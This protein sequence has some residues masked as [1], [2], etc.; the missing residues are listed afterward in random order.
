MSIIEVKHVTKDYGYG[1]GIFDVSF[2]VKKGEVFGFLGPNGAGKTTTIRH[3]MGFIKA[4]VGELYINGKD[5]WKS[6]A[7]IKREVGYLPGELAF[8]KKLTGDQ[9]IEFMAEER[10]VTDMSWTEKLKEIFELDTSEKI[11]KMSLGTKR[12]LAVVTAFIHDPKV[13][14]LDEPTSGLDPVMQER[15]IQFILNE[16]ERGKTILLSSHI[17]SEVDATCDRIAIIKEGVLVSTI[18]PSQLQR[19]TNKAFKVEFASTKDYQTFIG[20]TEFFIPIERPEQNQVKL[21]ITDEKMQ[22]LFTELSKV[23]VNFISEIKFTLEDYF[24]DFYDRKKTVADGE[25]NLKYGLH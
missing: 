25:E 22:Q 23:K 10:Q 4:Q 6:A 17:F 21:N 12:K 5:C 16:K 20:D 9:F 19:N 24:M 7:Y 3:L 14:I 15:F 18:N 11:K 13:L 2:E 1:R 8:P